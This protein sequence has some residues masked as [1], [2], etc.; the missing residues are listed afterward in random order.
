MNHGKDSETLVYRYM[1][2]HRQTDNWAGRQTDWQTDTYTCKNTTT[3]STITN[4]S[5]SSSNNTHTPTYCA[6]RHTDRE[7]CKYI[8]SHMYTDIQTG[9]QTHTHICT[10][11]LSLSNSPAMVFYEFQ[12]YTHPFHHNTTNSSS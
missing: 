2:I 4:S 10:K 1:H 5:R 7:T 3:T 9:R 6:Y 12:T 11:S 8:L